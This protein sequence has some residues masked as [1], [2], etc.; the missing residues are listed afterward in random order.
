VTLT[1]VYSG[2]AV[3]ERLITIVS[4]YRAVIEAASQ[5]ASARG[6]NI[7]SIDQ[8]PFHLNGV[9]LEVIKNLVRADAWASSYLKLS[10]V[11]KVAIQKAKK[12][13]VTDLQAATLAVYGIIALGKEIITMTVRCS[14]P[15]DHLNVKEA[16]EYMNQ[17]KQSAYHYAYKA[18]QNDLTELP[19]M[20]D[21]IKRPLDDLQDALRASDKIIQTVLLTRRAFL[22]FGHVLNWNE[23]RRD[24]LTIVIAWL[25]GIE[26]RPYLPLPTH[27]Q[28]KFVI[29]DSDDS[30]L[31]EV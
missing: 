17:A 26:H 9:P 24:T 15:V 23:T 21:E 16:R 20:H 12:I 8:A 27:N 18:G 5:E 11:A 2:R 3:Y 1:S 10:P 22:V 4:D 14:N 13:A 25:T 28:S 7:I 29:M 31:E 30:S 19:N 6:A